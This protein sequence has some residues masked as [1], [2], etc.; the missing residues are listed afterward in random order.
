VSLEPAPGVGRTTE[1][2]PRPMVATIGAIIWLAP[3]SAARRRRACFVG[4]SR[5]HSFAPFGD[6]IT[7]TLPTV[8]GTLLG[9]IK[10]AP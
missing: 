10:P 1:N 3:T 7:T 4:Y 8:I 5:L 2:H 6:F 9:T